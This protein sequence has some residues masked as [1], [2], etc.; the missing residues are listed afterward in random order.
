MAENKSKKK[1]IIISVVALV[2]VAAIVLGVI[3]IPK[4]LKKD[5]EAAVVSGDV[6]DVFSETLKKHTNKT[7]LEI[8]ID[9]FD[10]D[11]KEEAFAAVGSVDSKLNGHTVFYNGEFY[12]INSDQKVQL[13][14]G[15]TAGVINGIMVDGKTKY[16]SVDFY[17]PGDSVGLSYIYT[18]KGEKLAENELSGQYSSV[19]KDGDQ[20]I[21][22]DENYDKIR[23]L[24]NLNASENTIIEPPSVDSDKTPTQSEA[25]IT[26]VAESDKELFKVTNSLFFGYIFMGDYNCQSSEALEM[27]YNL[28]TSDECYLYA[29]YYFG[30]NDVTYG[31][32]D[33]LS[34]FTEFGYI[35]YPADNF[36]WILKN[37][38]NVT[39]DRNNPPVGYY[40]G[41][42]YYNAAPGGF[43]SGLWFENYDFQLVE[44]NKF[45]ITV[46]VF[47]EYADPGENPYS[48]ST[49]IAQLKEVDGK[50]V[51]SVYDFNINDESVTG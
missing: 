3:F 46:T 12:F 42:Y 44:D 50:R 28:L 15:D 9:D 7:L 20:I 26:T 4:L 49:Y 16:I 38:L 2:L 45:K 47:F 29:Q 11:G 1:I 22:L 21:A 31:R 43:G 32:S 27:A 19:T 10:G 18:V 34:Q 25:I 13:I 40:E 17:F 39:P 35:C 24:A 6:T 37:V 36:D 14:K 51:W 8:V 33:P 48:Y 41:G 30:E 23:F 5:E